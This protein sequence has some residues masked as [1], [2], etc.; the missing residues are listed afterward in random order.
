MRITRHLL[1]MR[2]VQ[3]SKMTGIDFNVVYTAEYGYC[4]E[5]KYGSFRYS[6]RMSAREL[7]QFL[8]GMAAMHDIDVRKRK[9]QSL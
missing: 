2:A 3:V 4:L 1:N 5:N 6:E 9:G 7:Y 8:S